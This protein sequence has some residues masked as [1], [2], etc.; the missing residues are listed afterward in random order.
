MIICHDLNSCLDHNRDLSCKLCLDLDIIMWE[1]LCQRTKYLDIVINY[2]EEKICPIDSDQQ[3]QGVSIGSGSVTLLLSFVNRSL[4][5][6][7]F[8]RH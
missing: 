1:K 4:A 2:V 3:I 7:H 6:W 5:A 8:W